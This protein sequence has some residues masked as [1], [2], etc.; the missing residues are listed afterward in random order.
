MA[1]F[2]HG[3]KVSIGKLIGDALLDLSVSHPQLPTTMRGLLAAGGEAWEAVRATTAQA[4]AMRPLSEVRLLAPVPDPTKYLAIGMNYQDH[5]D[6]AKARG[7]TVPDTQIWFNKQVSC[8]NGPY[9]EV[10]LP[11]VSKEHF[12]LEGELGVIIGRRCRHVTPE[13][14][15]E[16]IAGY[17]VANDLSIRDWQR[18]SPT[19]TLGKSF[20]THGPIGPFLVTPDEAG[21]VHDLRI[22]S[23]INDSLVQDARSSLMVAKIPEQIAYLSTVMTLEPGD[24]L[25]TGT[26]NRCGEFLHHPQYLKAGDVVKVEIEGIG[27]IANRVVDEPE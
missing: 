22:R 7:E 2:E 27:H 1:T 18:R 17:V 20:D 21:D 6:E 13:N 10:H 16:V 3:G 12:D 9:A 23:W 26:P 4:G 24:V 11:R 14:A 19:T 25:A 15:H 8:V 5:V